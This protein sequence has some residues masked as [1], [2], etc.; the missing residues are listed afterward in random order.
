[1]NKVFIATSLDGYIADK[2]GDLEW[3]NSYPAPA[4]G[5]AGFSDFIS[6]IDAIV[7]G[8]NTFE[9]V[10][11]FGI[12]WPYSKKVFILSNTLKRVDSSLSG[13]VEIIQGDLK[14]L[15]Q[16]L[17]QKG[18]KELYID[19][20]QVIQSFLKLDLIDEMTIT[21]VPILL[22][23][24]IPLFQNISSSRWTH[25]KTETFSNGMVQSKYSREKGA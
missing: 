20:G 16:S 15:I 24:G 21:K 2:N 7:M 25:V 6:S 4:E 22:G 19:G 8:R 14:V 23:A 17:N 10:L 3:L 1:M 13:R 12:E 18:F 9:K 5:D 11:S